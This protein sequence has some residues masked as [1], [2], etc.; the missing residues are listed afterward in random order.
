MRE[1]KKIRIKINILV[2]FILFT[3]G[4]YSLPPSEV[5]CESLGEQIKGWKLKNILGTEWEILAVGETTEISKTESELVCEADAM[6][7]N[8][9]SKL[10]ISYFMMDGEGYVEVKEVL[11]FDN[12]FDGIDLG[13]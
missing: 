3:I 10:K 12:I 5:S 9:R 6:T 11:D 4:C 13:W 1:I 8:G 7:E 2:L